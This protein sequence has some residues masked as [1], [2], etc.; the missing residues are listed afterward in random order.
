M[1]TPEPDYE[2]GQIV[3]TYALEADAPMI[4]VT[5]PD[6]NDI[7]MVTQ[8]GMLE[9]ARFTCYHLMGAHDAG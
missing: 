1:S 6:T 9:Y 8:L 3:I 5:L 7:P 2:L 4:N